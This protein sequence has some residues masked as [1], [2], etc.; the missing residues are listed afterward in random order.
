MHGIGVAAAQR[1]WEFSVANLTPYNGFCF[2][3]F[4]ICSPDQPIRIKLQERVKFIG[5]DILWD[6]LFYVPSKHFTHGIYLH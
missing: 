6:G 2:V 5:F 4:A 1:L 3:Q